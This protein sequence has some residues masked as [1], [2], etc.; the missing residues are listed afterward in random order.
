[1]RKFFVYAS[2]A[3]LFAASATPAAAGEVR[4]S[5]ANGRVTLFARDATVRE[6]LAEWAR[7]GQTRI[8]NAEKIVG[9]PVSMELSDVPEAQALDAVLRPVAGY[10]M[11]P[12]AAGTPGPSVYDRVMILA[13]SRPP[14]TTPTSNTFAARPTPQFQQMQAPP[15]D[16]D[17]PNPAFGPGGNGAAGAGQMNGNPAVPGQMATPPPG[18]QPP[19]AGFQPNAQQQQ[20]TAPRP[21]MLP[22]QPNPF[23]APNNIYAPAQPGPYA[24]QQPQQPL[25][26]TAAQPGQLQTQPGIPPQPAQQQQQQNR[27]PGGGGG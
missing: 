25:P 20:L 13:T 6:I 15:D 5:I 10:I 8:V 21:G 9:A 23:S 12:R 22:A 7:V 19:A 26:N 3:V 17:T 18:Y 1:M 24:P 4:L 14:A 2:L 11:A 16:D 27:R